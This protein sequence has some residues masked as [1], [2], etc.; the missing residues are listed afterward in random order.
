MGCTPSK[1][2][3]TYS[4]EHV[5]GD[6]DTCSTFLPSAKSSVS[7]PERPC[8]RLRL[9]TGAN[10]KDTF[11]TVP[12]RDCY[13]RLPNQQPESPDAWSTMS[14]ISAFPFAPRTSDSSDPEGRE[15]AAGKR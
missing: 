2:N 4:H 10:C 6:L 11:L 15:I 8:T 9:D 13:G 3:I 14:T 7:T 1:S 5:C 12:S